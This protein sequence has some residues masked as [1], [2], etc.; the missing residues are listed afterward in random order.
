MTAN[1]LININKAFIETKQ[2]TQIDCNEQISGYKLSGVYAYSRINLN[3][4]II[5]RQKRFLTENE[6]LDK[7]HMKENIK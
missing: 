7:I 6:K 5:H 4:P 2:L 3:V 1:S